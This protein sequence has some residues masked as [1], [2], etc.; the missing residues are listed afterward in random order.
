MV[1]LDVSGVV[2]GVLMVLVDMF[3]GYRLWS[4]RFM[5]YSVNSSTF[6]VMSFSVILLM[7]L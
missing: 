1:A 4:F 3:I 2:I 5:I 7:L 6:R